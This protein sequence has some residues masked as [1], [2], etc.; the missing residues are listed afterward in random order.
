MSVINDSRKDIFHQ[1]Q[2]T[3]IISHIKILYVTIKWS[4]EI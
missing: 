3:Q 4:F 1:E 2:T